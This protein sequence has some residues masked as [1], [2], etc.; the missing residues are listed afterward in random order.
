M[1]MNKPDL[2][3]NNLQCLIY[4]KTIPK[5]A[6]SP[7]QADITIKKTISVLYNYGMI[8]L[9]KSFFVNYILSFSLVRL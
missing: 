9:Y 2:A 7:I 3:L 8:F 5:S 6:V 1:Y 4:N